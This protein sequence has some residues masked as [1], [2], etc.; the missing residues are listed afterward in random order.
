LQHP[1]QD[2]LQG[3]GKQ[4]KSIPSQGG[5]GR[6]KCI[7]P[8]RLITENALIAYECFRTIRNQRSKRPFSALKI[9]M[10]KEYDKLEWNYLHGCL[11]KLG[12]DPTLI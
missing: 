4:V 11:C 3:F 1:L 10:M 2:R 6:A 8:S 9:D 5:V 7:F 12:F